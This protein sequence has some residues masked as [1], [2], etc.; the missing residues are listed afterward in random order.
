M[1]NRFT[2]TLIS[3]AAIASFGELLFSLNDGDKSTVRRLENETKK[4][5]WRIQGGGQNGHLPSPKQN[6]VGKTMFLPLPKFLAI[7]KKEICF[8]TLL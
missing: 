8:I 6:R 3:I 5:Q 2:T 1:S 7:S 4:L